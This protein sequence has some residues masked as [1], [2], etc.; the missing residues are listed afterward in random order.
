MGTTFVK[1]ATNEVSVG[2]C[3]GPK[4]GVPYHAQLGPPDKGC[5]IRELVIKELYQS[6]HGWI[7]DTPD[8]DLLAYHVLVGYRLSLSLMST[9]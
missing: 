3:L 4:T 8:Q 6:K 5:I 1:C 7:G 2:K 9:Y